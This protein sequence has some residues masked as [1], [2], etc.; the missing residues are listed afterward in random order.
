MASINP[1]IGYKKDNRCTTELWERYNAGVLDIEGLRDPYQRLLVR[2]WQRC[3]ALGVDVA[4]NRGLRLSDAEYE[5]RRKAGA[6]LMRK[7]QP[8]LR[9]VGEY[10]RDVPGILILTECT[11]TILH[12]EGDA[13]VQEMAASRSG[14]IEGSVWQE[15]VAGSNGIGS[16]LALRQPVHVFSSEHFCEGWHLWTCAASPILEPGGEE[17]LGVVDF[18]TV[19]VD[20]RDQAL[21]LAASLATTIQA[22]IALHRELER[23]ALSAFLNECLKKYPH[24]RLIAL[25]ARGK[26]LAG[27][28]AD[29]PSPAK[30]AS[31]SGRPAP[32]L[33]AAEIEAVGPDGV[34]VGTIVV[35]RGDGRGRASNRP[36]QADGDE[37]GRFGKFVSADP[38]TVKLLQGLPRFAGLDV[39]LL[40]TGETG[41]GKELLARH[42]HD[43]SPRRAEPYIAVNCGAISRSL[44][45]STFFGYVGGAFS[46]ADPKGRRGYFEAAGAGTL[47]LDEVGELPFDI[48]AALLRVLED[49]TFH[50][51]GSHETR[52]AHCRII[53]ATNRDLLR[54]V[55]DG[56][57]RRDL[58]YRL[59][60]VRLEVPPLRERREDIA[61]LGRLFLDNAAV[62][63]GFGPM[64]LAP[65][66]L[67]LLE[68]YGWPGNVRELRNT[69]EFA[70]LSSEDVVG[71]EHLP[72]DIRAAPDDGLSAWQDDGEAGERER[73]IAALKFHRKANKAAAALGIARSTLYR[74][75][76]AFGIDHTI[77]F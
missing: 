11:G 45:E 34:P 16:A 64:T 28:D 48:Q 38:T 59:N 56:K 27:G 6:L 50:R 73:I 26:P 12:I 46:G 36:G 41:T 51:V 18:T 77:Y 4:L 7:S 75:I 25:D 42:I 61:L 71:P 53:A 13:D 74:K 2:E 1:Y 66:T 49:G 17:L 20:Y 62:R 37:S 35:L 10:L 31:G 58:Y 76:E 29:E 39:N 70:A 47:F 19:A 57:F 8:I 52:R 68:S 32:E 55:A 21:A 44:L 22:Q 23:S 63:H 33:V 54:E 9:G 65:E 15:Q 14:I 72:D 5:R 67:R 43:I 40:V 3:S 60:V 69:I 30:P 24:D